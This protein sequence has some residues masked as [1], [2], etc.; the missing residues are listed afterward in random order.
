MDK[1][2]EIDHF[3]SV[4]LI[5]ARDA[6]EVSPASSSV[7]N[8]IRTIDVFPVVSSKVLGLISDDLDYDLPLFFRQENYPRRC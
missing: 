5:L 7:S 3:P 6:P 4:G 8:D 2:K 1:V